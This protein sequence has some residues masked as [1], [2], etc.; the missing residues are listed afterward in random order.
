ML[1]LQSGS[2]VAAALDDLEA[3]RALGGIETPVLYRALAEAK[4]A[5]GR[6]DEARRDE[7]TAKAMVDGLVPVCRGRR[8][9]TYR[10]EPAGDGDDVSADSP[11][12]GAGGL[13]L[14][15]NFGASP[16]PSLTANWRL[17]AP[18]SLSSGAFTTSEAVSSE[19]GVRVVRRPRT[20]STTSSV[21]PTPA[22]AAGCMDDFEIKEVPAHGFFET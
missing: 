18:A 6:N 10:D 3:A 11:Q 21:L 8:N 14:R 20:D 12:I 1:R 4:R 2:D 9:T 19:D 16:A 22:T 15:G 5:Q 17:I 13:D 7:E